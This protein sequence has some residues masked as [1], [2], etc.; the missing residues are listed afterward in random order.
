VIHTRYSVAARGFVRVDDGIPE[1]VRTSPLEPPTIVGLFLAAPDDPDFY[2]DDD[3]Q[4][5]T[6]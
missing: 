6:P 1:F 5:A 3:P 2:L 4:D